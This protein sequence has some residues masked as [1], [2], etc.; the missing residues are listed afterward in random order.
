[1]P[2]TFP[3]GDSVSPYAQSTLSGG[4]RRMFLVVKNGSR[5]KILG[6][7]ATTFRLV[8]ISGVANQILSCEIWPSS[9]FFCLSLWTVWVLQFVEHRTP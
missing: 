4:G 2:G 3:F 7:C 9:C 6:A 8:R 1:M 5:V